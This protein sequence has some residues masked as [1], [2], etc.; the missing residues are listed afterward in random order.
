MV[1]SA[2][3]TFLTLKG[4]TVVRIVRESSRA[5]GADIIWNPYAGT[6]DSRA[7]EGLDAVIH[8][9]GEPIAERWSEMK[10]AA[11]RRS[12]VDGTSLLAR[13]LAE[14]ASPPRVLVSASAM[15]IYGD[16]GEEILTE[17]SAAGSDFLASVVREWEG[18]ADAARTAGIR[19]AHPRFGIILSANGGALAK[20][21]PP[22]KLGAGG[23]LGPG[24]QWWSWI[25]MQD[26]LSGIALLLE[27]Q[28]LDGPINFVSPNPVRNT[29]FTDTLGRVL[30]RP[31]LASVPAFALRLL[32]GEM[33]G[34]TL[35][36]SQR[37]APKRLEEA[38]FVFEF[39]VLEKAL[40]VAVNS[41]AEDE[42][43]RT[44]K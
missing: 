3:T 33:A 44:G 8:L 22:F 28:T 11:I 21:L 43:K 24:S 40:I 38:G 19:V 1:G 12:R 30:S 17:K 5:T 4:I 35:L 9:A 36:A 10:K 14:L 15:G 13:R 27:N 34:A 6:L 42:A 32:F 20:M 31:T 16:R 25:A 39:P 2:L 41:V 23:K 29:E 18:A 7:L 26:V 37:V